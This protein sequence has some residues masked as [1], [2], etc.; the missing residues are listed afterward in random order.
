VLEA[1]EPP[2]YRLSTTGVSRQIP[3]V[4]VPRSV[5]QIVALVRIANQ[6][7][8]PL[9][10]ISTGHNW[11]YGAANPVLDGCA[12][13]DLS[14]MNRILAFD[15]DAGLVTV[16]PGV[17][18]QQLWDFLGGHEARF[19]VPVHGGGPDC[20]LLGNILERGYGI[21]PYA[22]HFLALTSLEAVLASG[23]IYRPAMDELGG[24]LAH[25][26][27][28]WGIGPYLDGLFAQ[29][30]LGIVTRGTIALAPVAES[31]EAFLFSIRHEQHLEETVVAV[32]DILRSLGSLCSGIN[33]MNALRMLSMFGPYPRERT[34]RGS[35]IPEEVL[36]ELAVQR[37]ISS[38]TGVGALYGNR[39]LIRASRSLIRQRLRPYLRQIVFFNRRN[40]KRARDWM[41]LPLP[42]AEKFR[43]QLDRVGQLLN[44]VSG[45]PQR[46]ALAL[47]YWKSGREVAPD[48]TLD[49]ARDRC[50]LIWYS[51]LV[52]MKP[53]QVREYQQL[54]TRICRQHGIDPL[55]TLTS[56]S[57]R[58]FDS[59]VP[60]L[61][62]VESQTELRRARQCYVALFEEGV[63]HGFVPYR[64]GVQQMEHIVQ[65]DAACWKMVRQ[66]K[67]ALDPHDIIAPGRYAPT[68]RRGAASAEHRPDQRSDDP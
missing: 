2:D 67:Q 46:T 10:P 27:L 13:V 60:L 11:G 65:P 19:Y 35:A 61:F 8:L 33:L 53:A 49:P 40:L 43:F 32:R 7:R 59:T 4:L 6:H 17:T 9:Y 47:A 58:L 45:I 51:P 34:P 54:V 28:K 63:Q 3:V 41:R 57:D 39:A 30:N 50:G 23:E 56:L 44:F 31:C 42:G 5:E 37:E 38:W 16:E 18:Q 20:S 1:G 29:G 52:P 25:R 55:I 12:V 62:D 15:V 24:K 36:R 64:V 26:A 21:T 66:I 22:D 14:K 68:S 48:T